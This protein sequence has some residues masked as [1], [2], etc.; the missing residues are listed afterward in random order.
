LAEQICGAQTNWLIG[1]QMVI[2]KTDLLVVRNDLTA[3][4]LLSS[5]PENFRVVGRGEVTD[6]ARSNLAQHHLV[7][8]NL[9]AD[10]EDAD[11]LGY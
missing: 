7:G 5:V 4:K 2:G 8:T 11:P 3:A 1:Y 10:I 9:H 6:V